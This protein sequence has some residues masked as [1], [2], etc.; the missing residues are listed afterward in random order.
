VSPAIA[1]L[2]G[3]FPFPAER[4][5]RIL[6]ATDLHLMDG[7]DDVRTFALL[8][9]MVRAFSPDLVFFTGDQAM[10]P[11]APA[12]Y[13]R[14]ATAMAALCV[15][16]TF[17]FGNHDAEGGITR[18]TLADA[19]AGAP[20]LAFATRDGDSDFC[21][22]LVDGTDGIRWLLFGFDTRVDAFYDLPEGRIWGYDT[23]RPHQI[24][25]YEDI[26]RRFRGQDG[27]DVSSLAFQHVPP[28]SVK[29]HAASGRT[30]HAGE[31]NESVCSAPVDFGLS[32]SFARNG[33]RG[34]FFGHDHLNDFSFHRDGITYAY[35]RVSGHYDYAMPGFPKG[36]RLI[37][38]SADGT[39]ATR[40]VLHRDL[41]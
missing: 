6:Q 41:R 15:P 33:T 11:A 3:T 14:L 27:T 34:V 19:V 24:A 13:R 32:E 18:R 10:S 22:A 16:W 20:G 31:M 36:V 1:G 38:L 30:G 26:V 7:P 37:D 8:G 29:I 35:G 4:P 5:F 9:D 17:I 23:V 39:F 12:L 21:L 28:L 2:A 40:I 25:W